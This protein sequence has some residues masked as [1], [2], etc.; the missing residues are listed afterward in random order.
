MNPLDK[1]AILG[2]IALIISLTAQ[3]M[4]GNKD[5]RCWVLWFVSGT[6]WI[7]WT[8]IMIQETNFASQAG[9]L[10]GILSSMG[11]DIRGYLEWSK[12]K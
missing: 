7:W 10:M 2:G 9:S 1:A 4:C 12:E 5:K 8:Y 11:L 3:Y 6:I